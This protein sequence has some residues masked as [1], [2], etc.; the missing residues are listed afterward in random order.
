METLQK[1]SK[2]RLDKT[3]RQEQTDLV[4]FIIDTFKSGKKFAMLQAPTGVGKSYLAC[5]LAHKYQ[6]EF[7]VCKTDILTNS[8]L[9]QQQYVK[10]YSFIN[11]LWGKD[12][13]H[14]ERFDTDCKTGETLC[15]TTSIGRCSECPYTIAR[16]RWKTAEIALTNFHMIDT[17]ALFQ[18]AT[19]DEKGGKLL[20]I[21]EAHSFDEVFSDFISITIS[22]RSL[23][24]MG[25]ETSSIDRITRS[26]G[27]I[28]EVSTFNSILET[29][30]V[31]QINETVKELQVKIKSKKSDKIVKQ[32]KEAEGFLGKLVYF[33]KDMSDPYR[34][35]NW[36]LE[37]SGEGEF[38]A[39]S[40]QPVWVG[41]LLQEH[42]WSK[43]TNIVFMSG[44]LLDQNLF[45]YIAGIESVSSNYIDI[46]SPFKTE[47]RPIYYM[48]VGK[49]TWTEKADT[50]K[51]MR[52]WIMKILKR[53]AGKKGIIHTNSYEFSKWIAESFKD[54]KRL[55]YPESKNRDEILEKHYNSIDDTVLVSPSM[56]TGVDLKDDSSR[57]QII[58]KVPY[59]SLGSEKIKRRKDLKPDWYGFK[60]CADIIQAY[61]R[62]T[63]SQDDWSETWILD[64]SFSDLLKYNSKFIPRWVSDAIV[65]VNG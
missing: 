55:L 14:C 13:Y 35:E 34:S 62:S 26:I 11:N 45:S 21:D 8:K 2:I 59:P 38:L 28:T 47:S 40:V 27:K 37:T 32:L 6:E 12:N 18:P 7:G 19:I 53:N 64:A 23:T 61:G 25:L 58:I 29:V 36:V 56:H 49:M 10:D 15:D 20:I 4:N 42:L 33:T 44:T 24:L 41:P 31:P 54:E 65:K 39:K 50:W 63:R 5:M 51:R 3:P 30:I 57:F 48:P 60:S 1:H 46:P 17:M 43:Y 52:P 16:E 9:L 22:K